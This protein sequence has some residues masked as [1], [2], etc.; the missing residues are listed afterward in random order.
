MSAPPDPAAPP[1]GRPGA[2]GAPGERHVFYRDLHRKYVRAVRGEGVYLYDDRGR[3]ILDGASGAAVVSLGHGN[4]RLVRV[5]A[6]Q[7]RT[8]AFAHLST[9]TNDPILRL[10]E[11]VASLLPEPLNRV[12]FTSGGSETVEAALKLARAYHMEGG[13]TQRYKVVSRTVSYHGATIG[14]LSMTGQHLRRGKYL[15]LLISF[16]RVA[17]CYCYRCPY[18]LSPRSCDVECAHDLERALLGEAP[19]TVAA[20]IVE[21]VIGASAPGVAPPPS[22]L[23]TIRRICNK[24][25]V[26]LVFDEVMCG[27]GRTGTFS[28]SERYGVV[29]DMICFSKGLSSGYAPL[30]ALVVHRDVHRRIRESRVGKFIH[31]HTFAGNPLAARV[32]LE[33]LT[34]LEEDGL[35]ARVGETGA[36]LLEGLRTL[37]R[38][39][40]VGDVRGVGLLL[41]VELVR[42]TST[43]R[44][45]PPEWRVAE[46]LQRECLRRGLYL[47][48]GTGSADGRA[49][50]HALLAPPFILT[51]EQAD[52]IVASLDGALGAVTRQVAAL[53]AR[54]GTAERAS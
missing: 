45:F 35:Y 50:D 49:G 37:R 43:R 23:P 14:A 33:V 4:E 20:F 7:A 28:A 34:I 47:Y 30:G 25:G 5:M 19:E 42:R 13:Q 48:P 16:P 11:K 15:P 2:R 54:E 18:G 21:P 52:E 36:H 8:L 38:H 51:R 32:G 27:A 1:G 24:H 12:Y 46:R 26:L 29:P 10:S 31:G 22:Y 41:G 44:P 6:E 9:F 39:P 53:E 17:T 40:I 3:R